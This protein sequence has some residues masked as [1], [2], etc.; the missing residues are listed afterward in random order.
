MIL[1]CPRVGLDW[2]RAGR[3]WIACGESCIGY[4][5]FYIG[6]GF[7]SMRPRL[8]TESLG[9]GLSQIGFAGS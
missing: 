3:S 6:R 5:S 7:P 4:T 1:V 8:A 2:L 9:F